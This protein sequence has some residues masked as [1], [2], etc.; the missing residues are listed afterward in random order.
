MPIIATPMHVQEGR[1]P[2]FAGKTILI[3]ATP[4]VCYFYPSIIVV[5]M[6]SFALFDW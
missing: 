5:A 2:A 6:D 1:E 4:V 3:A